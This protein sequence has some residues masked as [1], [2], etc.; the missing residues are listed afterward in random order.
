MVD[1]PGSQTDETMVDLKPWQTTHHHL[2]NTKLL[3]SLAKRY[4]EPRRERA[5]CLATLLCTRGMLS[6]RTV[7][8][9]NSLARAICCM[10]SKEALRFCTATFA[11]WHA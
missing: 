7:A 6:G 9:S 4:Q 1:L 8:S 5:F 2:L 3:I 10:L 11:G